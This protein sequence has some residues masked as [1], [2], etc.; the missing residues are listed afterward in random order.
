MTVAPGT[1]VDERYRVEALLSRSDVSD[2]H[3]ACD[4]A[5]GRPVAVKTFRP[6]A[7]GTRRCETEALALRAL[8]HPNVVALV[9]TGRHRGAPF[10]VTELVEGQALARRLEAGPVRA[11]DARRLGCDLARALAHV[12]A[13]GLVHRGPALGDVLLAADGR[14][15]LAGFGRARA[16]SETAGAD[17]HRSRRRARRPG[18]AAPAATGGS[19]SPA[20]D[21]RLLGLLLIEVLSAPGAGDRG[22][23]GRAGAE[24]APLPPG[25]PPPWP[26]LLSAMIDPDPAARPPASAVAHLLQSPDPAEPAVAAAAGTTEVDT[27]EMEAVAH[28]AAPTAD[29]GADRATDPTAPA[30]LR[31][32]PA[33]F[34]HDATTETMAVAGPAGPTPATV[35]SDRAGPGDTP[36]AGGRV[37]VG[38]GGEATRGPRL[39]RWLL[40][41]V[42]AL[43]L[44]GAYIVASGDPDAGE[45]AERA[46]AAPTATVAD[47]ATAPVP[48]SADQAP[49]PTGGEA[50]G[51]DGDPA[52]TVTEP[53]DA[54]GS[55]GSA[56][57]PVTTLPPPTTTGPATTTPGSTEV[58]CEELEAARAEIQA[59]RDQVDQTYPDD[60]AARQA[61]RRQLDEQMRA[62][63]TQKRALG[64]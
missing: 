19:A 16:R 3:R 4:L 37:A 44:L 14:A 48:R 43:A 35:G 60:P 50:T 56:G 61:L 57:A 27:T 8:D 1:V 54:S 51:P 23:P 36:S 10:L 32:A 46:G 45:P 28:G 12:H 58:T 18:G 63:D 33:V 29:P 62:V 49:A 22:G 15:V 20:D 21:V 7:T 42:L 6:G 52:G 41:V 11:A 9:D 13:R 30:G 17:T 53:A 39:V 26:D 2:V 25:L 38:A 5:T 64:C 24:A 47:D 31:A 40:P 34:D 55:A 59:E